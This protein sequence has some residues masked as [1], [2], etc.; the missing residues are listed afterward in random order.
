MNKEAAYTSERK[1]NHDFD[2]WIHQ[3]SI[4]IVND[5]RS[6]SPPINP[7]HNEKISVAL[8]KFIIPLKIQDRGKARASQIARVYFD[9]GASYN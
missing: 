5:L 2:K 3:Q 7:I 6:S 1:P 4:K 8:S 9:A